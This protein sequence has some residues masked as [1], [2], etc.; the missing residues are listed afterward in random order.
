MPRCASWDAFNDY[1]EDNC[2]KRQADILRGYKNSIRERMQADLAAMQVLP[3]APFEA[4]ALRSGQVTST[5]VVRYRG[6]YYSLP[7]ACGYPAALMQCIRYRC[8]HG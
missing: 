6:H 2:R 3:A 4:R 1:L 5:S 7:M 8:S